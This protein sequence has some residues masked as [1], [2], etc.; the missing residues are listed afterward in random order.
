MDYTTRN[1]GSNSAGCLATDSV[2]NVSVR[3]NAVDPAQFVLKR[4]G[5][6]LRRLRRS[7]ISRY[8]SG[9]RRLR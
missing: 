1:S 5:G 3:E 7:T 2:W 9:S 4:M 6:Y 8:R